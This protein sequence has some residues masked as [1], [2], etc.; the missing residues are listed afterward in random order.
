MFSD[1][2][3][4][5]CWYKL[6]FVCLWELNDWR[7][8]VTSTF[9]GNEI[10]GTNFL[11]VFCK[12]CT[13]C[14]SSLIGYFVL[15]LPLDIGHLSLPCWGNEVATKIMSYLFCHLTCVFYSWKLHICVF[16][17]LASFYEYVYFGEICWS[18]FWE[19][20]VPI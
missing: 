16:F 12:Y 13:I 1:L 17:S 15:G 10:S 5:Y 7:V 14:C 11:F 3:L 6:H 18:Q 8:W 19:G 4:F 9:V 2:L 20:R